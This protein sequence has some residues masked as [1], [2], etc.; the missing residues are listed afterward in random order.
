MFVAQFFKL[1]YRFLLQQSSLVLQ[2]PR[3]LTHQAR[4]MI[5]ECLK[6]LL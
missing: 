2:Q 6:Q 5:L 4:K 1:R 3:R